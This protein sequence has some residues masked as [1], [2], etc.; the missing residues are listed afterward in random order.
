MD[1]QLQRSKL[2]KKLN[3]AIAAEQYERA[4]EIRDSLQGLGGSILGGEE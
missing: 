3:E 4:A 1:R 2:L